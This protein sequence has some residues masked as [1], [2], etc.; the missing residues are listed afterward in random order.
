MMLE[1]YSNKKAVDMADVDTRK[2][3]S[4]VV[5]GIKVDPELDYY[6]I[7]A[8][9][10]YNVPFEEVTEEMRATIKRKYSTVIKGISI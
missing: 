10:M 8:S 3:D 6:S 5:N 7:L 4:T 1:I 2:M 9:N